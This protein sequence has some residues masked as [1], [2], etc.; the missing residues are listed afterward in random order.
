MQ[1]RRECAISAKRIQPTPRFYEDVLQQLRRVGSVAG[2]ESKTERVDS[3]RVLAIQELERIDIASLRAPN[4]IQRG[5]FV[6]S[7]R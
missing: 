6:F 3:R 2:L 5:S 7:I 4:A 1:P